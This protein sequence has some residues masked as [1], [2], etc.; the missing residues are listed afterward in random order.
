M[1]LLN[2]LANIICSLWFWWWC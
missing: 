2:L 1:W